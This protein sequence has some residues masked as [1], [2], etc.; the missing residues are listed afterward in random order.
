V[1]HPE[2][3]SPN[4]HHKFIERSLFRHCLGVVAWRYSAR[5]WRRFQTRFEFLVNR[6]TRRDITMTKNSTIARPLL[7]LAVML[8]AAPLAAQDATVV[9][10]ERQPVYQERVSFD[11]LDLRQWSAQQALKTRVSRASTRVCKQAVGPFPDVGVPGYGRDDPS[12]TCADLTFNDAR[13]QIL[14]AIERAK[15]GQQMAMT[16]V[17]SAPRLR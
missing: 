5:H 8:V 3:D 11:D 12:L 6:T 15:A 17:I 2:D 16:F 10:G 4:N 13:P 7:A 1:R 14:A 9:T